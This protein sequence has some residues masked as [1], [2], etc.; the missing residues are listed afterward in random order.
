[1]RDIARY[2]G[3]ALLES[4]LLPSRAISSPSCRAGDS[5]T[6]VSWDSAGDTSAITAH[7]FNDP[8][9]SRRGPLPLRF[10]E[11]THITTLALTVTSPKKSDN[12]SGGT[13]DNHDSNKRE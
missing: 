3:I 11:A 8:V 10:V 13:K 2:F 1:M 6:I 12:A 4:I 9:G 5:S 7:T